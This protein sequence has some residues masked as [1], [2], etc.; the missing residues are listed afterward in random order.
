MLSLNTEPGHLF[1]S[2]YSIPEMLKNSTQTRSIF[3]ITKTWY[4]EHVSNFEE[5]IGTNNINIW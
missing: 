1:N 2:F 5:C 3:Y 4:F